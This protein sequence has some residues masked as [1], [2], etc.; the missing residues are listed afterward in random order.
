MTISTEES[1]QY[2]Q[3]SSDEQFCEIT[4]WQ[5]KKKAFFYG[6][7]KQTTHQPSQCV[8]GSKLPQASL[9]SVIANKGIISSHHLTN[10]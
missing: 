2:N 6:K 4:F 3:A 1:T 8:I 9:K 7:K 5:K 10:N